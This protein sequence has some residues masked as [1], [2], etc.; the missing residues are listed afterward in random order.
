LI[1][2]KGL[3]FSSEENQWP[4]RPHIPCWQIM[5]HDIFT[6]ILAMLNSAYHFWKRHVDSTI[7]EEW[8]EPW[9]SE[10]VMEAFQCGIKSSKTIIK[11]ERQLIQAMM[12]CNFCPQ[13]TR[14][15]VIVDCNS[16]PEDIRISQEVQY[17]D[18]HPLDDIDLQEKS[19]DKSSS[20]D[21][22]LFLTD[23]RKI[24]R[25]ERH[26][27]APKIP[28]SVLQ[29][30]RPRML[31]NFD[32]FNTGP[33]IQDNMEVPLRIQNIP[34]FN[35]TQLEPLSIFSQWR[36]YG[37]RKDSHFALS[38]NSKTPYIP[39]EHYLPI[40]EST[41][42]HIL[43]QELE[44]WSLSRNKHDRMAVAHIHVM[45]MEEMLQN[46]EEQGSPSSQDL[47][48]RGIYHN[49]PDYEREF[50]HLNPNQDGHVVKD[51]H[52]S[53]DIDSL[54]W[55][56]NEL[57]F[58][59]E[60]K[61]FMSP[62]IRDKPP[63]HVNN[64]RRVFILEPQTDIQRANNEQPDTI[65]VKLS[66]IPHIFFGQFGEG[67]G[68]GNIYVF[69]PR[70]IHRQPNRPFWATLVPVIIQDIWYNCILQPAMKSI[71]AMGTM[72]YIDFT[73]EEW[74]AKAKRH[75]GN[76]ESRVIS[77]HKI[78]NLV[79]KM[80]NIIQKDDNQDNL[81]MFGSFFFL[82]ELR[83]SKLL[84]KAYED[85]D[86]LT[87]L[88]KAVP[89]LDLNKIAA[90]PYSECVLDLGMS[91]TPQANVPLVGM[92]RITHV[93][94]SYAKAGTNQPK[95]HPIGTL[96][97]YGGL[98]AEFPRDRASVT[99]MV[100]RSTYNLFYELIRGLIEFCENLDAYSNNVAFLKCINGYITTYT[101]A[102][103]RTYG[104]RDEYRMS[105]QAIQKILPVAMSK[106]YII[107]FKIIIK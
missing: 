94:A 27:E 42:E 59:T 66:Q 89:T 69:W 44:K 102:R 62:V 105:I 93:D 22:T 32:D 8:M 46:A 72:E 67:A 23:I 48:T 28:D 61:I 92:W 100:F 98:Q 45:G 1:F 88:Q 78:Q 55:T 74:K 7:G 29:R 106:V 75:K 53:F 33:T 52:I 34:I 31:K 107:F 58:N 97:D 99:H 19:I 103:E 47:F 3:Q 37:Y 63:I 95:I 65:P 51:I 82:V 5:R 13:H 81:D 80:R 35:R 76:P 64:H 30:Q 14:I 21:E 60:I 77:E 101:N 87:A 4:L 6:T 9:L 40:A 54:I 56:T 85:I 17:N 41:G 39:Q 50:I 73:P 43:I 86:V 57:Y 20:D 36:D 16:C 91:I 24:V 12:D 10:E 15:Q 38:F 2:V 84:V 71:A 104:V 79:D 25:R 11:L 26:A 18:N 68:S 96:S 70:M 90:D 83:G 49:P